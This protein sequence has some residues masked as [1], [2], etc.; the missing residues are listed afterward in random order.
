MADLR[1]IRLGIEGNSEVL[2][3]ERIV[4]NPIKHIEAV[5]HQHGSFTGGQ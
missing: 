1:I 5:E 2:Y 3:A 4:S